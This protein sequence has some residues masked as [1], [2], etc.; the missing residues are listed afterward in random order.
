MTRTLRFC[1]LIG[2][3]LAASALH[4]EG[5]S[6]KDTQGKTHTL[7]GYRGKW[8]LV[9]FWATW[10]PPCLA[11]IP[12]LIA[13]HDQHKNKDLV[14]IGIA[15]DYQDPQQVIRFAD[16]Y[17][18]SYPVVLGNRAI[19]AQIGPAEALPATYLYNPKGKLVAQH[20]GPLTKKTVENYIAAKH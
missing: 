6:L 3:L 15:M 13:L 18:M 11:E 8:V 19:A 14:V 20:V 5:F 1:L 12:D 10:C 4:A 7:D 2:A 9:N 17:F 16:D